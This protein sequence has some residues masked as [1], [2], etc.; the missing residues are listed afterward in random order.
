MMNIIYA[1][2][3]IISVWNVTFTIA[4]SFLETVNVNKIYPSGYCLIERDVNLCTTLSIISFRKVFFYLFES[5]ILHASQKRVKNFTISGI[6]INAVSVEFRR[7]H[8]VVIL[9]V[10]EFN[11]FSSQIMPFQN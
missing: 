4:L 3:T 7:W 1:S 11:L 9:W 8:N 5:C 10:L 2:Q 6:N